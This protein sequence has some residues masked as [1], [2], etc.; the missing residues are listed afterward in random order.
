MNLEKELGIAG[1]GDKY[2]SAT[3]IKDIKIEDIQ[4]S[5]G[6]ILSRKKKKLLL[7]SLKF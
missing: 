7:I 2:D 4:R 5:D 6:K 3:I 1:I